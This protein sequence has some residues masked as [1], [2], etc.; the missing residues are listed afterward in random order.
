MLAMLRGAV[1]HE[2][3]ADRLRTLVLRVI[4]RPLV[5]GIGADQP[6]R[7]AGLVASQVVGLAMTRYVLRFEPIASASADEL[8]PVLGTSLQPYLTDPL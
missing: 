2:D 4:L 1:S 3:S 6:D 5:N 7:R 8:A